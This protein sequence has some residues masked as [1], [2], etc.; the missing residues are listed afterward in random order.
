MTGDRRKLGLENPIFVLTLF[1]FSGFGTGSAR[2][3][4]CVNSYFLILRKD[5][6][7]FYRR[8]KPFQQKQEHAICFDC[9]MLH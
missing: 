5:Q 6:C 3:V 2:I 7:L 1:L 9:K 4:S 8:E